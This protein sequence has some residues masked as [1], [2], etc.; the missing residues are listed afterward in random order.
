M[1]KPLKIFSKTTGLNNK[2]DAISLQID[3]ESGLTEL[4]EAVNID[5]T[6]RGKIKRR[7]G[8][9]R[10]DSSSWYSIAG[11]GSFGLG[12]VGDSLYIIHSDGVSTGIRSGLTSGA[13]MSYQQVIDEIYYCNGSENGVVKGNTSWTWLSDT[14]P[15]TPGV[16]YDMRYLTAPPVGDLVSYLSSRIY[17]AKGEV[18]FFSL[19]W[20][21]Y[22]F[23]LGKDFIPFGA[24]VNMFCPTASGMFVG[25]ED[26]IV[27]LRGLDPLEAEV[28]EIANFPAVKWTNAKIDPNRFPKEFGLKGDTWIWLSKEGICVGSG[29]GMFYNLTDER[30]DIEFALEG[31]GFFDGIKYVGLLSP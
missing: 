5:I 13:K 8:F 29:D 31:A 16:K 24:T 30:L 28:I 11:F 6:D 15:T 2:Q 21:Y 10:L 9:E 19:P 27:F 14:V 18:V 12:L 22:W 26:R 20:S 7:A 17:I 3:F 4:S 1:E 23:N 25:T